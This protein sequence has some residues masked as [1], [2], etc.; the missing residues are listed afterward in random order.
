M[1]KWVS[2]MMPR[3]AK[4]MTTGAYHIR[5]GKRKTNPV[6]GVMPERA[7]RFLG[8]KVLFSYRIVK[9]RKFGF[10]KGVAWLASTRVTGFL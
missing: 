6:L 10:F 8:K 2:I 7:I 5:F 1:D 4:F 3:N 9:S